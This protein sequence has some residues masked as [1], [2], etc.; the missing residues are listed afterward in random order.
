[1]IIESRSVQFNGVDVYPLPY[2]PDSTVMFTHIKNLAIGIGRQL[3]IGRQVQERK[4]VIEYTVTS[5]TDSDYAVS[6][7]IVIG[8]E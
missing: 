3:R 2:M 8:Q 4:R 5:K 1:M 7:Q 6:D